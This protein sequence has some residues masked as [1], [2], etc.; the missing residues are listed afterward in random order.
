MSATHTVELYHRGET[1]TLA[2]PEDQ[3]ILEA[4]YAADID[5]P[6]ACQSGVCTT[7]AARVLSG[8][9]DQSEGMSVSPELQQEGYALLCVASPRSE[10]AIESEHEETVYQRQFAQPS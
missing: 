9:L 4:A 3:T 10:L 7:C 5:L 2:V 6:S 1:Y 8:S